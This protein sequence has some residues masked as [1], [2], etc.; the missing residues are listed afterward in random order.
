M[1]I[2]LFLALL[3]AACAS[4][5]TEPAY[6]VIQRDGKPVLLFQGSREQRL[7]FERNQMP[8]A[9]LERRDWTQPATVPEWRR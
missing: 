2:A 4:G 6:C 7:E 3:L 5:P 8:G 1:K 9:A